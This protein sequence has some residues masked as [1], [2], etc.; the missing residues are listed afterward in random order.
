MWTEIGVLLLV[1]IVLFFV[2]YIV[3][4]FGYWEPIFQI[5]GNAIKKA[6]SILM[7]DRVFKSAFY[8]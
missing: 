1:F 3:V 8:R 4:Y 5:L 6:G 2:L 7:L